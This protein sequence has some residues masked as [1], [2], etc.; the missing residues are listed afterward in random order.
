MNLEPYMKTV[1]VVDLDKVIARIRV[2]YPT[3]CVR[4]ECVLCAVYDNPNKTELL[5]TGWDEKDAYLNVLEKIQKM[6]K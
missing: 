4:F 6:D 5:G 3:V 1:Q 2:G